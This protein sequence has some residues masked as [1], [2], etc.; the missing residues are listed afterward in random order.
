MIRH[1]F[2]L[3]ADDF[4]DLPEPVPKGDPRYEQLRKQSQEAIRAAG[5][6]DRG[7]D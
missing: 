6:R 5:R 1:I 4:V 2:D 7:E 3:D